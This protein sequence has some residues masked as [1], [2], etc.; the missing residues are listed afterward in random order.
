LIIQSN[1][2]NFY[3]LTRSLAI[4]TRSRAFFALY[5]IL[6][7]CTVTQRLCV[8]GLLHLT[9]IINFLMRR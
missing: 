2:Q 7:K 5:S 9:L 8:P 1:Y 4:R 6:I 3:R